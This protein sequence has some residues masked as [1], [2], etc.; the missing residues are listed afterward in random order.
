MSYVEPKLCDVNTENVEFSTRGAESVMPTLAALKY[1]Y[2]Y[3]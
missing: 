2:S 1:Y 3:C